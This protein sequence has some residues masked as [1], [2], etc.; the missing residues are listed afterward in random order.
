MNS[1]WQ[2]AAVPLLVILITAGPARAEPFE[3]FRA[4]FLPTVES[5]QQPE[6][7]APDGMVWIPGGGF[8]MGVAD[9]RPLPSGGRE[10]MGDARPIHRVYVDGFWM[11]QTPVTNAEFERFVDETGYVTVAE[12]PLNPEEFPGVPEENLAPG[13]LV[14]ITPSMVENV[15]DFT[16]WW[17]WIPGAHWRA[18]YGPGSSIDGKEDAP[19][20]HVAWE[21]AVTYADWAGK[22]LPTEAEWEFAARGGLAGK[23]YP[24]GEELRP[25]DKWMAN[26]WQGR[27]PV[28]NTAKDGF[29]AIAPVREYPPND[30]GLYGMAGNVWEWCSDWYRPDTYGERTGPDVVVRNPSGPADSFDPAE[31]G[32]PKRVLRGGSFLCTDQYCTRYMVGTRGKTEPDSSANHTGFRLVKDP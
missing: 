7:D 19:V 11:D 27:F 28:E 12:R 6:E 25:G 32:V 14:F 17:Q 9:P 2:L 5:E 20:V 13:S 26:I 15:R 16:Q 18:P 21:D 1:K 24:W 31:P 4:Q 29:E 22:R 30:Y 23:P 3:A 8:S 10:A